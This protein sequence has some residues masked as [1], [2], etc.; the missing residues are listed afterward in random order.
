M[1]W[2]SNPCKQDVCNNYRKTIFN[3]VA[4]SQQIVNA[5]NDKLNE[6]KAKLTEL[7]ENYNIN[8]VTHKNKVMDSK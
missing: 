8:D 5:L 4:Y 7:K 6:L 3:E 2:N 1:K